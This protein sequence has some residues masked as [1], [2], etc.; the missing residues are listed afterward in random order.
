MY[1]VQVYL[2]NT[3]HFLWVYRHNK[4]TQDV[5][6]TWEKLVNHEPLLWKT[7][8]REHKFIYYRD[9]I[10]Y[11]HHIHGMAWETNHRGLKNEN[12]NSDSRKISATNLSAKQIALW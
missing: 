12:T 1:S 5:V 2:S 10:A 6:R 3:P 11:S 7:F 8:V 4:P 9:Q